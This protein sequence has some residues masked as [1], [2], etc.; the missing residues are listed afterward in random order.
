MYCTFCIYL[1]FSTVLNNFIKRAVANIENN[2]SKC[3]QSLALGTVI[4]CKKQ[5]FGSEVLHA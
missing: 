2:F 4:L 3:M 5:S 1:V